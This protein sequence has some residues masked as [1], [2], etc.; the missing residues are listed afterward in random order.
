[1]NARID[2]PHEKLAAFCQQWRIVEFSLFG[3]VLRDDFR[4]DSD[5]D[6]LVR[7]HSD[8]RHT[9]F[10]M[11]RMQEEL[12]AIFGRKVDL[13]S[14]RGVE[15]SRNYLRKNT[16]LKS[17]EVVYAAD[18]VRAVRELEMTGPEVAFKSGLSQS[19]VSRAVSWDEQLVILH[20]LQ[21]QK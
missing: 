15:Q 3:S 12:T 20:N 4:H 2:I 10:D 17:A 13:I 7:F 16:I 5:V 6:A 11:V 14:R 19:A 21:F 9:L 8:A 18:S 1:M